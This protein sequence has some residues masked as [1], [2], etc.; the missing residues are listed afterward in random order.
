MRARSCAQNNPRAIQRLWEFW[1][2]VEIVAAWPSIIPIVHTLSTVLSG[3]KCGLADFLQR[4]STF[5]DPL[6][7]LLSILIWK[8]SI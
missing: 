7:P 1:I 8:S 3:R 5:Q 6:L 4:C 2:V